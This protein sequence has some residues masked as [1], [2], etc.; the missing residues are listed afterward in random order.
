M[1][2]LNSFSEGLGETSNSV[3]DEEISVDFA[4]AVMQPLNEGIANKAFLATLFP[5]AEENTNLILSS[6]LEALFC[7]Y[8]IL[9]TPEVNVPESKIEVDA[10]GP[11]ND[12][13]Q[14]VAGDVVVDPAVRAGAV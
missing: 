9:T 14:P 6:E 4:I 3:S 10:K 7:V 1:L 2:T 11:V 5:Q 13:N 12:H 8:F